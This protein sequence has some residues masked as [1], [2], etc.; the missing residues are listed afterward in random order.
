MSKVVRDGGF[1]D[2]V[3]ERWDAADYDIDNVENWGDIDGAYTVD[4]ILP[5]R[6]SSEGD[7]NVAGWYVKDEDLTTR[8]VSVHYSSSG[9]R[10]GLDGT[11][12]DVQM[13]AGAGL[14]PEQAKRLGAALYQAG[15]ELER[16]RDATEGE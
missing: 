11:G 13:S 6:L 3:D 8:S 4:D 10:L 12:D 1:S 2:R 16:W 9:V 5:D 7:G 15:E 14:T